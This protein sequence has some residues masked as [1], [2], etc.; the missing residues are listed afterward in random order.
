MVLKC[1]IC[2]GDIEVTDDKTV[3]ICLYCGCAITFPKLDDEQR[4]MMFNRGNQYRRMGDFDRAVSVYEQIIQEDNTDAEAH[5]GCAISKFGIEY[6]EDPSTYDWIPTCHRLSFDSFLEDIDYLAALE[7]SDGITKKQYIKDAAK[8]VEV[9]KGILRTSQ[10]EEPFDVFIC[11]KESTDNG[12]RTMDSVLAQ[13]IYYQ[14]TDKGYRVFYSKITLEDK[15]GSEF[16]PYIFAALNSAKVMIVVGT[17]KEYLNAVWVKNEWSRYLAIMRKKRDRAILPCY[18]DMD[19]YDMPEA[20]SVLQSYDMS[21]I[22][23]IQDLLRGISKIVDNGEKEGIQNHVNEGIQT[24]SIEALIKRILIFLEDG[25]FAKA[26]NYC[27]NVLN[28]DPENSRAYLYKVMSAEGVKFESELFRLGVKIQSDSNF[29]KAVRFANKEEKKKLEKI[30]DD[31]QA[32]ENEK[33]YLYACG[34]AES[35]EDLMKICEAY[36]L[37]EKLSGY[38]D[39]E[40]KMSDLE[41]RF[42]SPQYNAAIAKFE[43]AETYSEMKEVY[44]IFETISL[45]YPNAQEYVNKINEYKTNWIVVFGKIL[46]NEEQYKNAK[47]LVDLIKESCPVLFENR[48][49][50]EFIKKLEN[51]VFIEKCYGNIKDTV[52]KFVRNYCTSLEKIH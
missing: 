36:C 38:K 28:T 24:S 48:D 22:G 18:K 17:K 1:K 34:V 13:D 6:V 9:Q 19:P 51:Y 31:A 42:I 25:D 37:F 43:K 15:V 12:D 49:H 27:E 29:I 4:A 2:G 45:C 10:N 32:Y 44:S 7:Y 16:E 35:E 40:E 8:I 52:L 21:K 11:Y 50:E 3:G 46:E 5:W 30:I 23:F 14:L 41:S 39:S 20:L 47:E 33:T 26:D